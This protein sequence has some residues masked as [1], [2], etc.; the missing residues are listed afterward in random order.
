ML[1][2]TDSEK[3]ELA[4]HLAGGGPLPEKWQARLFPHGT[5]APES[6]LMQKLME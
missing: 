3:K 5:P 4:G 6:G 2:L 1:P